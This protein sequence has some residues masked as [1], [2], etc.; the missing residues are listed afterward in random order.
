[1]SKEIKLNFKAYQWTIKAERTPIG[2][3]EGHVVAFSKIGSIF[4]YENGE[5][6]TANSVWISD[7]A[8]SLGPVVGYTTI[9]FSDGS[10]MITKITD[11]NF[12]VNSTGS[13]E[14]AEWKSEIIKGTGRFEGIKGGSTGTTMYF[15]LEEGESGQRAYGEGTLTYTLP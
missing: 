1:M 8:N 12:V 6:A 14:S 13:N 10:T 5:V 4:V 9:K 7:R 3:V 11:I 15:P 2:D